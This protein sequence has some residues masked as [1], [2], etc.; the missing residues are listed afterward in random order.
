MRAAKR[1]IILVAVA[2]VLGTGLVIALP[3]SH[4]L[5]NQIS[6]K[7]QELVI[8]PPEFSV[9]VQGREFKQPLEVEKNLINPIP[10]D[11]ASIARGA[12]SYATFCTPC[13]GV[14]GTGAGEVV[15]RGFIAASSFLSEASKART[16]GFMYSYI[17][18]GGAIMPPYS[19]GLKP[20]E[21]WDVVNYLRSIQ[22]Q[23]SSN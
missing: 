19:F 14:D 23:D 12:A 5:D 1:V 11:E 18:H 7:P 2:A 22:R 17:R 16:D 13:H 21:A 6:I 9:P 4:D 3:W 8:P 20:E 10:A 15:K